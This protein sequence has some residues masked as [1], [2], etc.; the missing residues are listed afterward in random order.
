MKLITKICLVSAIWAFGLYQ[1]SI[2]CSDPAG[3][4]WAELMPK[5][6]A[7]IFSIPIAISI[8]RTPLTKTAHHRKILR[9]LLCVPLAIAA[10]PAV[11]IIVVFTAIILFQILL[12]PITLTVL[13]LG[14]ATWVFI[15]CRKKIRA[16]KITNAQAISM[17]KRE[18][19]PPVPP[20]IPVVPIQKIE[21]TKYTRKPICGILAWALP[22]LSIPIGIIFF[23]VAGQGNYEGFEAW[24][25]LAWAII[26]I[27]V[28][29]F[30]A[31]I[32]AIVALLRK[33][34][35][36]ILSAVLLIAYGI[37]LAFIALG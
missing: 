16:R 31:P 37:K 20:P 19:I 7:L 24:G 26:P 22:P 9:F 6:F 5:L 36:P 11:I 28:A 34:R 12:H 2:A 8:A 13:F 4:G 33:E 32:L 15:I 25:I 29:L 18:Y 35:Y 30:I 1:G 23:F 21:K 3:Q 17:K 10:S 14:G 27:A